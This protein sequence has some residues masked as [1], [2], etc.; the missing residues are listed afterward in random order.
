MSCSIVFR[1]V[2]LVG[3]A[4]VRF[5]PRPES[6]LR[7]RR[8]SG[9]LP[10]AACPSCRATLLFLANLPTALVPALRTRAA[11]SVP[12]CIAFFSLHEILPNL[13]DEAA[14]GGDDRGGTCDKD[15]APRDAFDLS[16]DRWFDALT[17]FKF[18]L[19]RWALLLLRSPDFG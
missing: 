19:P 5:R 15:G 2:A 6:R 17:D 4:S 1:V 7:L 12:F 14:I 10:L 11:A 18:V 3:R 16:A 8:M 13:D 9:G